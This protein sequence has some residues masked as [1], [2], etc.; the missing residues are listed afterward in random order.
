MNAPSATSLLP[1]APAVCLAL[2]SRPL[3]EMVVC[4]ALAAYIFGQAET[5]ALLKRTGAAIVVRSLTTTICK[6]Q[7]RRMLPHATGC[8][9]GAAAA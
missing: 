5:A 6:Q 4:G 8:T 3:A 7:H 1:L 9:T 2:S